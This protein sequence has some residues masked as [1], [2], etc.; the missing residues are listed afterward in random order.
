MT[1]ADAIARESTTGS[2]ALVTEAE[3]GVFQAERALFCF[4]AASVLADGGEADQDEARELLLRAL[5]IYRD[6]EQRNVLPEA[7]KIWPPAIEAMLD[8]LDPS[9]DTVHA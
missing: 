6:L 8:S 1:L 9:L 3:A 2:T 4:R 5:G 7:H